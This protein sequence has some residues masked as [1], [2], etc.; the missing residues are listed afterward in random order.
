MGYNQ[1]YCRREKLMK[2]PLAAGLLQ[3]FNSPGPFTVFAPTNRA[4]YQALVSLGA[5]KEDVFEVGPRGY[6]IFP[7]SFV[8]T[9]TLLSALNLAP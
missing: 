8:C 2:Q 1:L 3:L 6:N 9:E 7:S 5:T 4:W